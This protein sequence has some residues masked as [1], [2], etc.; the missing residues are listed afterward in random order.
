LDPKFR[1]TVPSVWRATLG[2]VSSLY[3]L[4]DADDAFLKVLP[5]SMFTALLASAGRY[6]LRDREKG[7]ALRTLFGNLE[8]VDLD[9]QGR[10]RVSDRLLEFAGLS[11]TVTM[12]G[13]GTFFELWSAARR[14]E[15]KKVPQEEIGD[16]LDELDSLL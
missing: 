14:P 6:A 1:L 11:G 7:Q 10:I 15:Q 12:V 16:A 9:V 2:A 8:Q 5:A 13:R 3:V 4:P